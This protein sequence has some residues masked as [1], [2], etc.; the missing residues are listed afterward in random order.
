M[1]YPLVGVGAAILFVLSLTV[2]VL[3]AMQARLPAAYNGISSRLLIAESPEPERLT[4]LMP[5]K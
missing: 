1:W 5:E 3:Q 4:L 2:A